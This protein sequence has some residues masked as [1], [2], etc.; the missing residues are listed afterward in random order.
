[1]QKFVQKIAF[2]YFEFSFF[3]IASYAAVQQEETRPQTG[4][5]MNMHFAK[6]VKRCETYNHPKAPPRSQNRPSICYLIN[7]KGLFSLKNLLEGLR[8]LREGFELFPVADSNINLHML[9]DFLWRRLTTNCDLQVWCYLFNTY[10]M[11]LMNAV[12]KWSPSGSAI[13]YLESLMQYYEDSPRPT[14][15]DDPLLN[16]RL[17]ASTENQM[18]ARSRLQSFLRSFFVAYNFSYYKVR[19][20][21]TVF[22]CDKNHFERFTQFLKYLR[23]N[24]IAKLTEFAPVDTP[25]FNLIFLFNFAT[26]FFSN[27]TGKDNQNGCYS[28]PAPIDNHEVHINSR[29]LQNNV[30]M[31]TFSLFDKQQQQEVEQCIYF[32]DC[33]GYDESGLRTFINRI[34]RI[35]NMMQAN[36]CAAQ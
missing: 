14:P 11:E 6:Y 26:I 22:L 3:W 15:N 36:F 2:L 25:S 19:S 5:P 4:S 10:I 28:T 7:Q 17:V 34:F 1:M 29:M 32:F 12:K 30:K 16:E 35:Q 24:S 8:C 13:E 33:E 27:Y 20:E 23:D 31:F 9:S 21:N 18:Q